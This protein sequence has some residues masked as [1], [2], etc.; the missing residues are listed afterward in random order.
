MSRTRVLRLVLQSA[1]IF[2]R[3]FKFFGCRRLTIRFVLS[4]IRFSDSELSRNLIFC[5]ILPPICELFGLCVM[6]SGSICLSFNL[7]FFGVLRFSDGI[8]VLFFIPSVIIFSG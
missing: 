2:Y 5:L 8:E 6:M 4:I 7:S 1:E 3:C